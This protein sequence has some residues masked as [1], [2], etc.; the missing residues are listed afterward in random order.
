MNVDRPIV[1]PNRLPMIA[2]AGLPPWTYFN[3]ELL[4]DRAGG[5]V[6]PPLAACLPCERRAQAGRLDRRF[7]IVGERA[8]IVRGKDNVVRAFHNVCRH[9]GSAS[10]PARAGAASAPWSVRSTAGPTISTAR[11]RAVPQ[12]QD[13]SQARSGD[14]MAWCRSSMKSGTASS[15]CASSRDRSHPS[16]NLMAQHRTEAIRTTGLTK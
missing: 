15:S 1:A 7:D 14:S 13:L 4:R 2:R 5:A 6:P 10:S 16:P 9:R 3:K 11:L 12:G 8:L